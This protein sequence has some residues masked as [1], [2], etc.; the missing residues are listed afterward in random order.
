MTTSADAI[1][2]ILRQPGPLRII[3]NGE[4]KYNFNPNA[5]GWCQCPHCLAAA[6]YF[7]SKGI[8]HAKETKD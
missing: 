4:T 1:F 2:H 6:E 3:F 7:R 8:D 5:D